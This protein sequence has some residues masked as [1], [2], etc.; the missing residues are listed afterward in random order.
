MNDS[1]EQSNVHELPQR[2]ED[3][4]VMQRL[5][6]TEEERVVARAIADEFGWTTIDAI[7]HTST[8]PLISRSVVYALR[9]AGLI[10]SSEDRAAVAHMRRAAVQVYETQETPQ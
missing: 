2:G 1:D 3:G 4:E 7:I 10:R 5:E 8:I 9:G 6:L